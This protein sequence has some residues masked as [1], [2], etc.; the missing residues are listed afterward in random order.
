MI[1][2]KN[3]DKYQAHLFLI[4][5]FS[6]CYLKTATNWHPLIYLRVCNTYFQCFFKKPHLDILQTNIFWIILLTNPYISWKIY[7]GWPWGLNHN[8]GIVPISSKVRNQ[9][10]SDFASKKNSAE[11]QCF[12]SPYVIFLCP[13]LHH[14][15]QIFK[16][17]QIPSN[18]AC[19]WSI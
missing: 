2:Y 16:V 17:V 1:K 14:I 6:L 15:C 11:W 8:Y 7:G 9:Q 5:R 18:S 3:V 4:L 12:V 19:I 13:N 10:K